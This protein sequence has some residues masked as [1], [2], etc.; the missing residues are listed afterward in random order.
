MMDKLWEVYALKYAERDDRVR[1]DSFILDINHAGIHPMDYFVWV[2]KSEHEIILVDTGFDVDEAHRRSRPIIRAPQ[3]ALSAL[4]LRPEDITKI[5]ITHLHY[6]HAGSLKDFPKAKFYVQAAEL[7]YATG[8]CMCED[9]LRMPYTG[10]H[11]CDIVR[12]LYTGKVIFSDGDMEVSPGVTVHCVGGHS[13]GLQVVRV[14]T[15]NGWLCLASDATHYYENFITRKPFPIVVDVEEMLKG[16]DV[17]Q[18]LASD[19]SLII[20]G[21]DPLVRTLF[22][23]DGDSGFLWRLDVGTI[24]KLP[25]WNEPI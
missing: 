9:T 17:I 1:S 22:P 19:R 15:Q 10:E 25:E 7:A 11:I 2:L 8:P 21:H 4:N 24:N 5:I 13:R 16:F 14:K 23:K 20:P 3:K 12:A 18:D 6:D